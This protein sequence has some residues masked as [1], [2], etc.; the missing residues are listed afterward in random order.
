[1]PLAVYKKFLI[2]ILNLSAFLSF[3]L[4]LLS[5]SLLPKTSPSPLVTK[6]V[7]KVFVENYNILWKISQQ[8]FQKYPIK[9]INYEKGLMESQWLRLN[10]VWKDHSNPSTKALYQIKIYLIKNLNKKNIT[11]KVKKYIKNKKNFFINENNL[12]S[13][14]VEEKIILYRIIQELKIYKKLN[15][16]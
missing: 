4:F 3:A 7:S 14:L 15:P 5:C 2:N 12:R 9:N 10:S 13:N 16:N 8:V 1:M 6:E 11:I